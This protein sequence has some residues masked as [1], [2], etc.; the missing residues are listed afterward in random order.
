MKKLQIKQLIKDTER[1]RN[2]LATKI[3]RYKEKIL[4]TEQERE[5]LSGVRWDF[6]QILGRSHE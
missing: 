3:S 2:R 4:E 1:E 5:R 6:I